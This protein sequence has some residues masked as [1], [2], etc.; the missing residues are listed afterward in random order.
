MGTQT[1]GLAD[2]GDSDHEP[3]IRALIAGMTKD[4]SSPAFLIHLSG[5]GIVSD[6][7]EPEWQGK[8]QPKIWNDVDDI[9]AIT[10]R[11]DFQLHRNVDKIILAAAAE[12]GDRLK[13]AIM[14]PPDIYGPGSGPGKTQSI[15]FPLYFAQAKKLGHA[16]FAGE[17]M[18]TRSWVHID[19][20]MTVY[21]RLVEAAVAG[22]EGADWGADVSGMKT[23]HS[24]CI[25][26]C[27]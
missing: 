18:N 22:G 7:S 23:S 25:L 11:E 3:S 19:D 8:L 4:R 14:C 16:F 13:T 21:Q 27:P 5:T 10:S 24:R 1:D 2:C 12:H 20:L 17:G 9:E 15:Y 6:W 26:T